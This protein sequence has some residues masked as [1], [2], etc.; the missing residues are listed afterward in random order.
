MDSLKK[1]Y[2]LLIILIVIYVGINFAYNGLDTMNSL[3]HVNLDVG[4]GMG[5]GNDAEGISIGN[6]LF[7]SV[8]GFNDSKINDNSVNLKDSSKN[9]TITVSQLNEKENLKD[10]VSNLL[11]TNTNITSNQTIIQ[12]GVS[13]Y[14]LYEESVDTYNAKIYFNKDNKNYLIS[15]NSISY[16]NS[17]YFINACKDI[18]NSMRADGNINY[19]RY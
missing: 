11:T 4:L 7:D 18:I 3:S 1:L 6:S 16:D 9:M 17:D 19:S 12:N 5:N 15:G 14:F 8:E 2:A 10:T 13:A